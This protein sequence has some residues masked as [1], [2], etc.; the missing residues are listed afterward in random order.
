MADEHGPAC[1]H[2]FVE[3]RRQKHP[4]GT[5]SSHWECL[6]CGWWFWPKDYLTPELSALRNKLRYHEEVGTEVQNALTSLRAETEKLRGVI[7]AARKLV[8]CHD[9]LVPPYHGGID[10]E[11]FVESDGTGTNECYHL[12]DFRTALEALADD[13]D[14]SRPLGF[15]MTTDPLKEP[16]EKP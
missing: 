16:E 12:R 9:S 5:E 1:A 4:E 10:G 3:E 7:E 14:G 8:N 15:P 11:S 13:G 2:L 6:H